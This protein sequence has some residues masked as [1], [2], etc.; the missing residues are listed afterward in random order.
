[1]KKRIVGHLGVVALALTLVSMT[2]MGGTVAKYTTTVSGSAEA[3]VAK[4]AFDLN[5]ATQAS[6][7]AA[8]TLTDLFKSTYGNGGEVKSKA[9]NGPVV[10]PGTSGYVKLEV[11]NNGE[12]AITPQFVITETNTAGIPLEYAITKTSDSPTSPAEWKSAADIKNQDLGNIAV[13]TTDNTGSFYLHWK[14]STAELDGDKTD[15]AFGI[16]ES[17]DKITLEIEC[18]VSQ[19]LPTTTP[20]P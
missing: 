11:K 19:V 2:L 3:T 5:G 1:M 12:V 13:G 16:K 15:T 17:L 9:D 7:S 18:T 10:A 6:D 8:I 20:A 4:F 14:W